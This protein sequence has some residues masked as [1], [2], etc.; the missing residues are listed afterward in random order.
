MNLQ[1]KLEMLGIEQVRVLNG[2][3]IRKIAYQVTEALVK[4]FPTMN[5]DYNNIL[6][7]LLNCNMYLTKITKPISRV[8]YIYENNSIYFDENLDLNKINEQMVHEC[9]H[10]LQ[11]FRNIKGRLDKIG[12]CNFEDFTIYGLG[13]NEAAVQYISAKALGNIP[14][15][16][17]RYGIRMRT[18]SPNYYPFLTNLVEQMVFLMG[19]DILIRG[20]INGNAK[21]EDELLNT[22]EANTKKIINQFDVMVEIN[23]GLNL[24]KNPE[25]IKYLQQEIASCYIETQ[26]MIYSTYFEKICPRLTTVGEVDYYTQKA[27][28]HKNIVGKKINETSSEESFYELQK[29][30]TSQLNKRLYK[31]NKEKSKNTLSIIK[32]ERFIR[33]IR[34]IASYFSAYQ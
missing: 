24:E 26:N 27:I 21:F 18:I 28:N 25:M 9:I 32:G 22:F 23:N 5:E 6:A 8:N 33:L 31:I 34:K 2:E 13:L 16:L 7:K 20:T 30:V 14:V 4:A 1:K 10:Y 19:E 11:D 3:L 12:L 29:R 15:T 17:E